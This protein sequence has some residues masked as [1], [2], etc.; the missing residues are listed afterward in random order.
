MATDRGSECSSVSHINRTKICQCYGG[1]NFN[2]TENQCKFDE[3]QFDSYWE[4]VC[5]WF[6][7]TVLLMIM[8]LMAFAFGVIVLSLVVS[9]LSYIH[10]MYISKF[11]IQTKIQIFFFIFRPSKNRHNGIEQTSNYPITLNPKTLYYNYMKNGEDKKKLV[12]DF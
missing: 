12:N 1:Y 11:L 10:Y 3:S 9:L 7:H 5:D 6:G 2:F 8:F 4:Y